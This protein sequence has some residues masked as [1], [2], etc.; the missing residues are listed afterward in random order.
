[1]KK[2]LVT[3]VAASLSLSVFAISEAEKEFSAAFNAGEILK[4]ENIFTRITRDRINVSPKCYFDAAEVARRLNREM[5][6]RDRYAQYIRMEQ[7]WNEYVSEAAWYLCMN[8]GSAEHYLRLTKGVAA[9]EGLLRM[10]KQMLD[11]M[12]EAKR[13]QDILAI[14]EAMLIKFKG[15]DKAYYD[16]H[17]QLYRY[18]WNLRQGDE[19]VVEK[20]R[21]LILKYPC[22]DYGD[23]QK[24]WTCARMLWDIRGSLPMDFRAAL[25]KNM[26]KVPNRILVT[27]FME[28]HG[29]HEK[30]YC[31]KLA[32]LL[33][34]LEMLAYKEDNHDL[35]IE[36]INYAIYSE[37]A[38]ADRYYS[39]AQTNEAAAAFYA[40]I[41]KFGKFIGEKMS[42]QQL[43]W[44]R[45]RTRQGWDTGVLRRSSVDYF[46]KF[47]SEHPDW[48]DDD[49]FVA[50]AN[51]EPTV[52]KDKN[53]N[54]IKAFIAR[55]PTRKD[56]IIYR[57]RH[58]LAEFG[59]VNETFALLEQFFID[60]LE[61]S[62][63]WFDFG[64]A[65]GRLS[66]CPATD[67][68]KVNF[69]KKLYEKIG[70]GCGGC[71]VWMKKN[72]K[73]GTNQFITKLPEGNAFVESIDPNR[74][75]APRP[76]DNLRLRME[77]MLTLKRVAGNEAPDRAHQLMTEI[78]K[79]YKAPYPQANR[80]ENMY[81]ERA[82]WH[83]YNELSR[84]ALRSSEKFAEI[85]LANFAKTKDAPWW[86]LRDIWDNLREKPELQFAVVK[87]RAVA[88]NNPNVY[89]NYH[90]PKCEEKLP[91]G[92]DFNRMGY[93]ELYN[94]IGRNISHRGDEKDPHRITMK[95]RAQGISAFFRNNNVVDLAKW[96]VAYP[97]YVLDWLGGWVVSNSLMTEVGFPYD[98]IMNELL[99]VPANQHL[100]LTLEVL[101][102]F[103]MDESLVSRYLPRFMANVKKLPPL[104]QIPILTAAMR[105]WGVA[106]FPDEKL[107]RP[108]RYLDF[109]K[110]Y[111]FPALKAISNADAARLDLSCC[112]WGFISRWDQYCSLPFNKDN[113]A[114]NKFKLEWF[115]EFARLVAH[116]AKNY[117]RTGQVAYHTYNTAFNN[118]TNRV[119]MS[120]HAV[121]IGRGVGDVWFVNMIELLKRT[122]DAECWD[123]LYLLV[124]AMPTG[125]IHGDLVAAATRSRA[126][127]SAHLT[128]VYPVDE[129]DPA[130]P[131]YVAADEYAHQNTEGASKLLW[132][133]L[134]VFEREAMNL[135]SEFTAWAVNEMRLRRG[136]KDEMLIRARKIATAIIANESK[137]VPE[138]VAAMLLVRAESY[139]DQQNFEAAKLEYQSIRDNPNYHKTKYGRKAMF[140]STDLLIE[141]GAI[142]QVEQTLEYWLSQPDNEIQAQA[143]YFMARIAFDRKDYDE[144]IKQLKEVFAI[145]LTHTE[146]RFL[147]GKW[148]LATNSEVDDTDVWIGQIAERTV[149]RPGQQLSITVQDRNLSVAGGGSSIPVIVKTTP[150]GDW[151]NIRL[152]PSVRDPNLFKGVIDVKLDKPAMSNSVLEVTG[153]DVAS[154]EI[155]PNFLKARGLKTSL[156]KRLRI[157]DDARLVVNEKS[158][159]PG[160]PISFMVS[161]KDRS[162][163]GKSDKVTVAVSTTSGDRLNAVE[164]T[165]EKP[166]TGIFRGAIP[167]ALPP[168]RA[169]A[170]DTA[171]GF[172]PGDV[173]NSTRNGIW[174]SVADKK[175]VKWFAVDTMGSHVVSNVVITMERP[176]EITSLAISGSLSGEAA[177]LATL[178][179][180]DKKNR[181]GLKYQ[182]DCAGGFR[183][184]S[185][186]RDFMDRAGAPNAMVIS[187]LRY[188]VNWDG[189]DNV[190][191][192]KGV[193]LQPGGYDYLRFR[194]KPE[195][196]TAEAFKTLAVMIAI[197]GR[198][199][200]SL[201]GM[202]LQTAVALFD[203]TP[204]AHQFEM[205]VTAVSKKTDNFELM[206]EPMGEEMRSVPYDW[207]D[208]VA[209]KEIGEFVE[210]K[211]VITRTADGFM[212]TFTQP[213]RLRTLQWDFLGRRNPDVVIKSLTATDVEGKVFL[214]VK[215]DF[216][217]AQA[218]DTLEVAPGDFISVKYVDDV[219]SSGARKTLEGGLYSS[220]NDGSIKFCFEDVDSI[221]H[222]SAFFSA[223][224]YLP[225]DSMIVVVNDSDLDTTDKA[226]EIVAVINSRVSGE[227]KIRLIERAKPGA[228][229]GEG[230]HTGTFMG[231][232]KTS[233][234]DPPVNTNAVASA[235]IPNKLVIK[236]SADDTLTIGY[237]DRE[238]TNP[239]VPTL[240]TTTVLATHKTDSKL[241]LFHSYVSQVKDTSAAAAKK[242]AE[243][244]KRAG[245][246]N[247]E[248]LYTDVVF[249]EPIAPEIVAS[250]TVI[251]IN[252][253][254]P[255]LIRMSD[256]SRAR[257][258]NSHLTLEAVTERELK[259]SAAEG[260]EPKQVKIVMPLAGGFA[261]VTLK[262][263]AETGRDALRAG[264]FNG[265]VKLV[266]GS[267]DAAESTRMNSN[268]LG[269]NGNDRIIVT[270][271]DGKEVLAKRT[272]SLVSNATL[273]LVDSSWTAERSAAHIGERFFLTVKDSDRDETDAADRITLEVKSLETGNHRQLLLTETVPHSG[274][275]NGIVS[276]VMF[277]PNE[278]I[279]GVVTGAVATAEE[280][281]ADTRFAAKY[282]DRLVFS[283][284]DAN[285]LP[286]F[287]ARTLSVTGTVYRGS[288]GSIRLFSKRF[289][290]SDQAVLVQFRLAEC[291]FEQAKE[292][293][294]LK[295]PDKSS[296]AIAK[297]RSILEEA[298]KNYPNSSHLVQGEFLLANLFQELATEAKE[299]KK[300]DEAKRLYTE[301]LARFS[302]ML[303]I[304][305]DGEYAARAQYHKALCME[306]LEDYRR[307]AEE[308]VK[309][310]YLF[311]ESELVGDA[312]IRLATH[313]Y[314]REKRYDVSA[315]VYENFQRR[316]SQHE[317]APR[318]LFMCGS[319]YV[320][321]AEKILQMIE[322]DAK[323][324]KAEKREPKLNH[325]AERD[326][327]RKLYMQAA[328]A[329][330]KLVEVY[331]ST[332]TPELRA[333]ALYWAGDSSLRGGDEK[334]SYRSLKRCVMDYP[335]TEWAKRARGLLL[336]Q[337]QTFDKIE[338]AE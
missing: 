309:M 241:T 167:T 180:V 9:S 159:R 336:M 148:K 240:R 123:A 105:Y 4:C 64:D 13:S 130:Y 215:S 92:L 175:P 196:A 257:H 75:P 50:S 194:F 310:T 337:S 231:I 198:T 30:D 189:R 300:K 166:F 73:H 323:A 113:E 280:M 143:H 146:A 223:Y 58:L 281:L 71:F 205:F 154:Y 177:R 6:R 301:A 141:S 122:G 133:N 40:K 193:F 84:H 295:Q 98:K 330:L 272:F 69:L 236:T 131:L 3:V 117:C 168:P 191:R 184:E 213:V 100:W 308:Y 109:V 296:E 199:V 34:D 10:G 307:A 7:G 150:G 137:I 217:D 195:N 43:R 303:A 313:Y 271:R 42:E 86:M 207:F 74:K 124:N 311:P 219:T 252:S 107:K 316:F 258:S 44:I 46:A 161:D 183:G 104:E 93:G 18:F 85:C 94:F 233:L 304:W 320:K 115:A 326:K 139:R 182:T 206:W 232:V 222:R 53:V 110:N 67:Q 251:A 54:S 287:D 26:G 267:V 212:A 125:G 121:S 298:L 245:N 52:R 277:P 288:D 163:G 263:G 171:T 306:M 202:D 102:K 68:E 214:P 278:K 274:I 14:A 112:D 144:C 254:T 36:S 108:D 127:A 83:Y 90:L 188:R 134:D 260:R 226:D 95:Q 293:R 118:G 203:V 11:S 249:A 192:F 332:A 80:K 62:R 243:I 190:A 230:V 160:N 185:F 238:N 299:A 66:R 16:V 178:P 103:A 197:D 325:N 63:K 88:E 45:E 225:G 116:G 147:Q 70:N 216:S 76:S 173:I 33:P 22:M 77:E 47:R 82:L 187:N 32:K 321:E 20:I 334:L 37:M 338:N 292:H 314:L 179:A 158:V 106:A 256:P 24:D 164:L 285:V 289:R 156:P 129:K 57:T 261:G 221:S 322:D 333:Q 157:V 172:N 55:Y 211:A 60:Y 91:E 128:G 41:E 335:E 25:C 97:R 237:E 142:S 269:V 152:Y 153:A 162:R 250:N 1:M 305:P 114:Y 210:D 268:T 224:R 56:A 294:K 169:F 290:D 218:N 283:Y 324:A 266:V 229:E 151:E 28:G 242:L 87:A 81:V 220:F 176:E 8:G 101:D 140:R 270:V 186:I 99:S 204:G 246:E 265:Q 96:N 38:L 327:I 170:S 200:C 234:T 209:H 78:F 284:R 89:N 19:A 227:K 79:E 247:V 239:G 248:Y 328:E 136:D 264:S 228:K 244:R 2:T 312:T 291:L 331:R 59:P 235:K 165:E 297:G 23:E 255:L 61:D 174:K 15:N 208:H 31:D 17:W 181:V 65:M 279:P 51:F 145:D 39:A 318:A 286:G 21:A 12:R 149:I 319:C 329:F 253:S 273:A 29:F 48:L 135:P 132:P 5:L 275:F 302:S 201:R 317:K 155:D 35:A 49:V 119:E 111:Y 126:L 282:G 27:S 259:E 276:P 262:R 72:P 138:L 120:R 315:H